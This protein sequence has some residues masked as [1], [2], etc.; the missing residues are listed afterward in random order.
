[1]RGT[2]TEALNAY[3]E[4]L[5]YVVNRCQKFICLSRPKI[6]AEAFLK[7]RKPSS[8]RNSLFDEHRLS[9]FNSLDLLTY[10]D[11]ALVNMFNEKLRTLTFKLGPRKNPHPCHVLSL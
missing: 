2:N 7:G 6:I 5:R 8:L 10:S 9:A 4:Q 3:L 1:M 11:R